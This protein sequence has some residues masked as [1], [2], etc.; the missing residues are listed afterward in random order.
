MFSTTDGAAFRSV[1][2]FVEAPER[3]EEL[4]ITESLDDPAARARLFPS[5][6]MLQR[7]ADAAAARE[8]RRGRPVSVIRVEVWRTD[9]EKASLRGVERRIGALTVRFDSSSGSR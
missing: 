1:R 9:F 2:L 4:N 3:S 7:L 8:R 5:D 6:R